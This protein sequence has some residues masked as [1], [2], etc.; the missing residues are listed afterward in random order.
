MNA[1]N[2]DAEEARQIA[3]GQAFSPQ[4]LLAELDRI[5]FID[6]EF[7]A[8]LDRHRDELEPALRRAMAEES[9]ARKLNASVLLLELGDASGT[10]GLLDLLAGDDRE[11]QW[12]VLHR[13]HYLPRDVDRG[14]YQVPLDRDAICAAVNRFVDAAEARLRDASVWVLGLLDTEAAGHRLA[15]LISHPEPEVRIQVVQWLSRKGKDGGSLGV[16]EDLLLRR[17]AKFHDAYRLTGSLQSLAEH[18]DA[19]IRLRAAQIAAR[20]A[21]GH[22]DDGDN[23]TANLVWHCLKILK[24]ARAPDERPVLLEILQ[25]KLR[26]MVRGV[27]LTRLAELEGE[28]GI[29]RLCGALQDWHL[30]QDAAEGLAKLAGSV[31]RAEVLDALAAALADEDREDVIA[32]LVEAIMVIGGASRPL[33]EEAMGR[34]DPRI[35]MSLHWQLNR[36]GPKKAAKTLAK[37][38][39]MAMPSEETLAKYKSEWDTSRKAYS[40]V[41]SMLG[42]DRRLIG[43]D[44]KTG[45]SPADH[46]ELVRDLS[47]I[48]G[49]GFEM[50]DVSQVQESEGTL[51]VR[52]VHQDRGHSFLVQQMGR[53][54]D[55]RSTLDGLNGILEGLGRE[56]RFLQL[57]A[58]GVVALITFAPEKKFLDV[59]RKLRI[60]MELDPDAARRAGVDYTNYVLSQPK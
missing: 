28:D 55:L 16:I 41:W 29:K 31:P 8:A 17:D 50:T 15:G 56:E 39:A 59:A 45:E 9:G 4:R 26:W 5:G 38:G 43:F 34:A 36:I 37:A 14:G 44:C 23:E 57:H 22:L 42:E 18:G 58:G 52:F 20:Y 35:A 30:R 53:Y 24:T 10:A 48:T 47:G 7:R 12:Q 51:R 60:P 27:A 13:L 33:L 2:D 25:S 1:V 6:S 46:A 3:R 32:A 19:D 11:M 54:Y 49:Q 21:L 40:I